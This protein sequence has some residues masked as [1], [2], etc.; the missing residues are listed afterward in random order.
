MPILNSLLLTIWTL[1][2]QESFRTI[3]DRFDLRKGHAHKIF[4]R[5]CQ[6]LTS[7]IKNYIKWPT[8]Q[9][10][11]KTVSH[12]NNF[13]QEKSFP[14]VIGCVDGT[15]ILIP[16]PTNDNS[17]Y[18]RKGTHSILLQGICNARQEFTNVYC[19][20]P[21]STH[22]SRMWQHSEIYRRLDDNMHEV[23]PPNTYLLGDSAYPLRKFLMVPFR[24]NG[25]LTSRQKL[26]NRTL[27]ST[28]V[29]IE[30]AFGR[31]KGLFRRLKYLN[32]INLEYSKYIILSSCILHNI[33][34]RDNTVCDDLDDNEMLDNSME[35][36]GDV[37]EET[38]DGSSLRIEIMNKLKP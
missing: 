10:A 37:G 15:H 21:G 31:L 38:S 22:D 6:L 20:W 29:V 5:I 17:Y 30:N 27:S 16:G 28:R 3:G 13:R 26:F 23:I 25:H 32:I 4:I 34:I 2:N 35:E 11:I 24:D 14:N 1:S 36:E 9:D 19:G 7:K 8:G 33:S 18:N 12:F